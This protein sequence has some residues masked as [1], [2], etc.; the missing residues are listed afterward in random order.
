MRKPLVLVLLGALASTGCFVDSQSDTG[1]EASDGT[2][3]GTEGSS[4]AVAD[5][6]TG[7]A[8]VCPEYCSLVQDVCTEDLAQYTSD[9]VCLG[10]C[11]ALP[12][13]TPEDQLGN[14]AECRRFQA[15]QA[16]ENDTFCGAA[17]PTG[18]NVCGAACETF[19][20]LATALC[21]GELQQWPDI[22]SCLVDCMEFPMDIDFNAQVVSGNSYACRS[23]HLSVASLDPGVHCPHIA[24]V[25][26]VC[27]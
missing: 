10:V 11:A 14:T 13:G 22:P 21:T 23:Y 7:E 15:V 20:S 1:A 25:S 18:D 26:E 12:P 4:T 17:G 27:V 19:C 9:Q 24:L 6:S 8:D 5:S 16:S 3:Q 2:T